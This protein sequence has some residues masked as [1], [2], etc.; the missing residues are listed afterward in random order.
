M[1]TCRVVGIAHRRPK[2]E[3]LDQAEPHKDEETGL[4]SCSFC[5]VGG[6]AELSEVRRNRFI[7]IG[8]HS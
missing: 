3:Q 6:F 2:P 4:W 8:I 1:I 7:I 5:S